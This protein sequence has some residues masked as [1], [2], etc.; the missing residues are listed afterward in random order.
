MADEQALVNTNPSNINPFAELDTGALQAQHA[1]L[2]KADEKRIHHIYYSILLIILTGG[3]SGISC[4]IGIPALIASIFWFIWT[5][6]NMRFAGRKMIQIGKELSTRPDFLR[7]CYIGYLAD[8]RKQKLD[9]EKMITEFENTLAAL[10]QS[11][12]RD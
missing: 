2:S 4:L 7:T 6:L 3:I 12:H 5:I 10:N 1:K 11:P 9:I 8:L